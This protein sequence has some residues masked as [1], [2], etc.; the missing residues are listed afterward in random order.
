MKSVLNA[1]SAWLSAAL[2]C[3]LATQGRALDLI[4]N[5]GFESGFSG[6]T[7]ADQLGSDGSF[8][9][10]NGTTSPDTAVPVPA[11]PEGI[12]A[13]MSDAQGPGSH[14]L[15]QD[16]VIPTGVLG[17]TLSF[18]RY[19]NNQAAGFFSPATLDFTSVDNQQARADIL[20]AT[21]DPFSVASTDVLMN[22]FQT[23]PGDPL[24]SGYS[25]V[26]A[27]VSSLLAGHGGQTV[28]L[29]FAETDNQLFLNFG[30][31][32]VSL[33]TTDVIPEPGTS[34]LLGTGLLP[35]AGGLA[36]RRRRS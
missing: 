27:D 21:A 7:R 23:M 28:R 25:T 35:L 32:R 36:R 12:A 1:K 5:G 17:G 22:L 24:V 11:P 14:V 3:V 33:S 26:S 30:V 9:L 31:D 15:Y 4:T 8:M 13:A 6:W 10:Q 34:L 29:R 16:F 18:E 20:L 2:A 19:V